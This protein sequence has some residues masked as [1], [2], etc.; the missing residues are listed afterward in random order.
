MKKMIQKWYDQLH[1]PKEYRDEFETL[2]EWAKLSE[3]TIADYQSTGDYQMDFLMSLYFCE[4]AVREAKKKGIPESVQLETLSDLVAWT[5]AYVGEN[6]RLGLYEYSW[7]RLGLTQKLFKLGRL[8]FMPA[9]NQVE[10]HIPAGAP[11]D[12]IQCEESFRLA[13]NFFADLSYDR[14]CIHSWMLDDT[15]A[16]FLKPDSNILHFAAMFEKGER[17]ESD[18]ALR[19][20]F[21]WNATRENLTKYTPKNHFMQAMYDY[22]LGGGKLYDVCGT[23]EREEKR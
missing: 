4:E 1:F 22:V 16:K 13:E 10:V 5:K 21:G 19:Y 7:V 8:E 20:V 23:R 14:Y 11:V 2:L 3:C 17:D 12:P 15:L 6:Q 18:S 9:E